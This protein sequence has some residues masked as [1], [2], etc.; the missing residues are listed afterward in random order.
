MRKMSIKRFKP[1]MKVSSWTLE[2][3]EVCDRLHASWS[4][5]EESTGEDSPLKTL[6]V[7]LSGVKKATSFVLYL[8]L[9]SLLPS[10]DTAN[11][12]AVLRCLAFV[13]QWNVGNEPFGSSSIWQ[14]GSVYATEKWYMML[15]REWHAFYKSHR[16]VKQQQNPKVTYDS[17]LTYAI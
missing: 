6:R 17:E 5:Q 3:S 9:H 13:S 16:P 7:L 4:G 8:Y 1:L 11:R 14:Q 12:T 2:R 15:E 10:V